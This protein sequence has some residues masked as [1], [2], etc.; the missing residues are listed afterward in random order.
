MFLP[1]DALSFLYTLSV[2]LA[3][4]GLKIS[5]SQRIPPGVQ[6]L[7]PSRR[8]TTALRIQVVGSPALS[9][10]VDYENIDGGKRVHC[11]SVSLEK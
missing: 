11:V 10:F 7:F 9:M 1:F 2:V 4:L 5:F 3:S 6:P 8:P